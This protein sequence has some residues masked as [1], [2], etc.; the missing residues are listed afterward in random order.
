MRDLDWLCR[1]IAHR[2][3]HES[4]RGIIENSPSAIMAA[5]ENDYAIEVDLQPD[6]ND[7][8]IVFHD[9]DLGRLTNENGP[10]KKRS[11][12]ELQNIRYRDSRDRILSL[13]ALLEMV[14][15]RVPLI[16]EIKSDWTGPQ[17][18]LV[19]AIGTSLEAYRGHAA[20]MS[21]D[22]EIMAAFARNFPGIARGLIS[23]RYGNKNYWTMLS[24]R[25]RFLLRHLL[26]SGP[27]NPSFIA[28]DIRG[29]PSLAPI[30]AR[31][32][33]GLKLLTWTVRTSEE[34]IRAEKWTD[35]MIFEGF[36]P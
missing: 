28:Y 19:R 11:E 2:G 1:P 9:A 30:T 18:E 10:L 21:F 12:E 22:P 25:Q 14:G 5:L 4:Q 20:T 35:A 17:L 31:K 8:P 27:A 15:G 29:L 24:W 13:G 6:C 34:R 23:E 36:R 32:L 33:F 16:I 26:L 3:L 7:K